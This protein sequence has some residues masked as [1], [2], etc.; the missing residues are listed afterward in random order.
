M[1]HI[2]KQ[3]LGRQVNLLV[4]KQPPLCLSSWSC[5]VAVFLAQLELYGFHIVPHIVTGIF[6]L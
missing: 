6:W 5:D 2:L 3:H 1:L 4:G